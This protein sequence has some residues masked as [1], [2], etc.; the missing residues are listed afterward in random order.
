MYFNL[1]NSIKYH[2]QN[3]F[4][5]LSLFVH[6]MQSYLQ[7]IHDHLSPEMQRIASIQHI[8]PEPAMPAT[9]YTDTNTD[10]MTTLQTTMD[11]FPSKTIDSID[12]MTKV[13]E[14]EIVEV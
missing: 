8:P 3:V 13:D 4:Y 9:S 10:T 14:A 11:D 2:N 1:I 6:C 5:F 12:G 7:S